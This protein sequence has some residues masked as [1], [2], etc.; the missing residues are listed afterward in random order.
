MSALR[1]SGSG[2][3]G[4]CVGVA[5]LSLQGL[6]SDVQCGDGAAVV[7]SAPQGVNAVSSAVSAAALKGARTRR[8]DR[9]RAGV[10]RRRQLPA[11]RRRVG[12]AA[13]G[14]QPGGW[15]TGARCLPHPDRQ[16]SA[17]AVERLSARFS[18][19]RDRVPRQLPALAP[20]HRTRRTRLPAI[21]PRSR[22]EQPIHTIRQLNLSVHMLRLAGRL[23]QPV[24]HNRL[25]SLNSFRNGLSEDARSVPRPSRNAP[26]RA[27]PLACASSASP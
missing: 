5:A 18:R 8:R 2:F 14:A 25:E 23:P 7:G 15:R 24:N 20:P 9:Y 19:R 3:D 10:R 1:H 27:T 16:Q 12:R 22:H 17:W 6:R 21:L 13:R 11:L 4:P 26:A